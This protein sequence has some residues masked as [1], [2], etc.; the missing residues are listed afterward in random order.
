M[1]VASVPSSTISS[2]AYSVIT[3]DVVTSSFPLAILLSD[4][5]AGRGVVLDAVESLGLV[6]EEEMRVLDE[7]DL[8]EVDS[9]EL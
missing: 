1:F 4:V 2:S 6:V 3:S 8:V 7:G 9:E 5:E